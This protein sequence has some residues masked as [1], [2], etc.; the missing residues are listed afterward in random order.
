MAVNDV[1]T[2]VDYLKR[3]SIAWNKTKKEVNFNS[4]LREWMSIEW[5]KHDDKMEK[6]KR[7]E[8]LS[9][10]QNVSELQIGT[11]WC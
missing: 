6:K 5:I 1:F 8:K 10:D 2:L 7:K 3:D 9:L 4:E 11:N